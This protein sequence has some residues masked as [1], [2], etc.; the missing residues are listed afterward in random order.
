MRD[1][2]VVADTFSIEPAIYGENKLLRFFRGEADRSVSDLA[3]GR[4]GIGPFSSDGELVTP[5]WMHEF[6]GTSHSQ[7]ASFFT[8]VPPLHLVRRFVR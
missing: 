5:S 3:D 7:L 4:S 6:P 8:V 1:T 2:V